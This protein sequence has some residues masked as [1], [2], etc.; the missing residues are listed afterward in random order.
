ML[1]KKTILSLFIAACLSGIVL[2]GCSG[3]SDIDTN[4]AT[5]KSVAETSSYSNTSEN[6]VNNQYSSEVNEESSEIQ[7]D[8]ELVE[9]IT[10]LANKKNELKQQKDFTLDYE[11]K[12][13]MGRCYYCDAV[14]KDFDEDG[15][16]E[17]VVK[18]LVTP[19]MVK[20]NTDMDYST[21]D[22]EYKNVVYDWYTVRNGEAVSSGHMSE[23]YPFEIKTQI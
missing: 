17:M 4:S 23:E 22:F 3:E 6:I 14:I 8:K 10:I 15:N 9:T 20:T 21:L 12:Y 11:D 2:T 7:M 13:G 19:T 18:Y 1:T 16:Y 5:Q